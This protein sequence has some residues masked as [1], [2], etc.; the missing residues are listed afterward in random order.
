MYSCL[1]A[2]TSFQWFQTPSKKQKKKLFFVDCNKLVLFHLLSLLLVHNFAVSC[3]MLVVNILRL[4][5][6]TLGHFPLQQYSKM[7]AAD[8]SRVFFSAER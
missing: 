6:P 7:Q 8:L 3:S 2:Q 1:D 5:Y 4:A